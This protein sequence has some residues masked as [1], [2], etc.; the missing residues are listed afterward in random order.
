M[1]EETCRGISGKI[2]E[3]LKRRPVNTYCLQETR[4]L[5]LQERL[6]KWLKQKQPKINYSGSETTRVWLGIL[7]VGGFRGSRYSFDW[8]IDT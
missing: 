4:W 5:D 8:K 1:N 6:L 3:M 2:K 7:L